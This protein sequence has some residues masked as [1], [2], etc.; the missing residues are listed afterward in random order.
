MAFIGTAQA[1]NTIK[2]R[3]KNAETNEPVKGV[4]AKI[5]ET[6]SV[7]KSDNDGN[8]SVENLKDGNYTLSI[9]DEGYTPN[10]TVFKV[11]SSL[12]FI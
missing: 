11:P 6:N 3:L 5:E 8:I 4:S 1:Q 2:F 10:K 12:N 7:F 9:S